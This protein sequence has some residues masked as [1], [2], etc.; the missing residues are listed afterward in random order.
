MMIRLIPYRMY[1]STLLDSV[2]FDQDHRIYDSIQ[3][4]SVTLIQV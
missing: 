4:D 1:N 3:L 2:T